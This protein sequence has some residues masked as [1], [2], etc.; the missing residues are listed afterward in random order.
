MVFDRS[1]PVDSQNGEALGFAKS[2]LAALAASRRT[3]GAVIHR[4]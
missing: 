1:C 3:S 4:I 2:K